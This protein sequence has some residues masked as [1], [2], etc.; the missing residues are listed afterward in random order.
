MELSIIK[1][2]AVNI[3]DDM[4]VVIPLAG[5]G[6]LTGIAVA[7]FPLTSL[8]AALPRARYVVAGARPSSGSI[9][10]WSK[11]EEASMMETCLPFGERGL[12]L[13]RVTLLGELGPAS[14]VI[15]V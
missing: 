12:P 5:K 10:I 3:G 7:V 15:M 2:K 13:V 1:S 8:K 6:E 14:T 11:S 4:S 9:F